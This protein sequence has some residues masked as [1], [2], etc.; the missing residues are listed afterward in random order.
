MANRHGLSAIPHAW[1][2]SNRAALN[3]DPRPAREILRRWTLR[4]NLTTDGRGYDL[5][6]EGLTDRPCGY[7]VV[8]DARGIF[9]Q[10]KTIDRPI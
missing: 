2:L 7:A 5:M 10:S 3:S 9:W 6:P 4:L 8:S 1:G